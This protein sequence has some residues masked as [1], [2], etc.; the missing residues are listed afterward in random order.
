MKWICGYEVLCLSLIACLVL[1]GQAQD[2]PP[3]Q[4]V[5]RV[6][7]WSYHHL[8]LSGGLQAADLDSA[9]VEPRILYRLVERNL[10][11]L[12]RTRGGSVRVVVVRGGRSAPRVMA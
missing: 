3:E 12:P 1:A 11:Q 10:P 6:Q 2:E 9:K 5:G 8:T 4:H 7:D